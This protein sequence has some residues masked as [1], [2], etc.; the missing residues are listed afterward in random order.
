MLCN[1]IADRRSHR[2]L[3]GV[4]PIRREVLGRGQQ[5]LAA[6]EADMLQQ[7]WKRE[8]EFQIFCLKQDNQALQDENSALKAKVARLE[9]MLQERTNQK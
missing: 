4:A 8:L 1:A 7:G 9:G 3:N 2:L 5:M 6:I